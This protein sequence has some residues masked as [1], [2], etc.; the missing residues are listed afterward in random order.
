M[1]GAVQNRSCGFAGHDCGD[2]IRQNATAFTAQQSLVGKADMTVLD[3]PLTCRYLARAC[4]L[5]GCSEA[6]QETTFV[7]TSSKADG[8][9]C[10][11]FNPPPQGGPPHIEP[12][13]GFEPVPGGE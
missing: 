10:N 2:L 3:T 9:A 13:P 8:T 11:D 7:C 5:I 4:Q 12:V 6:D 1:A